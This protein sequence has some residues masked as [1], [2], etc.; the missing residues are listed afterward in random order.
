MPER[1][2]LSGRA[3]WAVVVVILCLSFGCTGRLSPAD[4]PSLEPSMGTTAASPVASADRPPDYR[5]LEQQLRRRLAGSDASLQAVRAFLVAVN[6]KTVLSY[7]RNFGPTDYAQVFSVTKSV[8]SILVGVAI[9]DGR[10]RLDQTLPELLPEYTDRMTERVR[11][12]TLRQLLTM[13]S[14]AV[15]GPVGGFEPDAKD[16]VPSIVSEVFGEPGSVFEYTDLSAHLVAVVLRQAVDRP[17]LDYAREKLFDPLAIKTRPAWQGS[18]YQT[19]LRKPGFGWATDGAGTNAGAGGLK[20]TAPDMLKIGQLYADVGRW[21]GRQLV[22]A[23]WVEESTTDQLTPEQTT[24]NPYGY[25]WWVGG[26]I[27]S[28]RMFFAGGVY[29]QRIIVVP[30]ARL[31]V[32]TLSDETG[33][34]EPT[35][36]FNKAL[37]SV[38]LPILRS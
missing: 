25:L 36:E 27:E 8:L 6:G 11:S 28:Q 23:Q 1:I 22:S 18:D 10:L 7:Y 19:G 32:V 5:M 2:R 38:V 20:L 30:G 34:R 26:E 17:L 35:E 21:Q 29:G 15:D 12:I 33:Y 31:V 14:G 4:G 9:D 37:D 24:I 16:P 3:T 13:T